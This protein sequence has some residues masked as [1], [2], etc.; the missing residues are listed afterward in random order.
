MTCL[1]AEQ[2]NSHACLDYQTRYQCSGGQWTPWINSPSSA[3]NDHEERTR[4][5]IINT[6]STTCGRGSAV[7]IQ[8]RFT[9]PNTTNVVVF[10]GPPDRLQYFDKTGLRC[11]NADNDPSALVFY[12]PTT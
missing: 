1:A 3:P 6:I 5:N 8:A 4:T 10:D 7:A 9:I 12:V 11:N 2:T